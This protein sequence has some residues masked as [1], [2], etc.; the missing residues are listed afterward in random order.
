MMRIG[1]A[2]VGFM[3]LAGVALVALQAPARAQSVA[4]ADTD[5]VL[6][7]IV[8]T[9]QKRAE[10]LQDVPVAITALTAETLEKTGVRDVQDL[11]ALTP[12]LQIKTSD[13]S[14]NPKVFIRG[15][16]LN[17]FNANAAGAVGIY[18]DGVFV[19]SPWPSWASFSTLSGWRC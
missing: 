8:V 4:P 9:A 14:A 6:Q 16:G 10:N 5:G 18:M 2:G 17:D 3:L 11:P 1:K 13:A 12:G 7:E 15:V 19:A